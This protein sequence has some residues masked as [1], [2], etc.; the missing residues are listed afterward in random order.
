MTATM[1]ATRRLNKRKFTAFLTVALLGI[2]QVAFIPQAHANALKP[3]P[4]KDAISS[5]PTPACDIN[6][7]RNPLTYFDPKSGAFSIVGGE[8]D[9]DYPFQVG[10]FR[11]K[12]GSAEIDW[13]RQIRADESQ[14]ILTDPSD[15]NFLGVVERL[16][17]GGFG[18]LLRYR[19]TVSGGRQADLEFIYE[20]RENQITILDYQS[21]RFFRTTFRAEEKPSQLFPAAEKENGPSGLNSTLSPQVKFVIS[22]AS[23][24]YL[25]LPKSGGLLTLLHSTSGFDIWMKRLVR[26]PPMGGA[27]L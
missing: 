18:R 2:V 16:P 7:L 4:A 9:F 11:E 25:S 5:Q 15:S 27:L 1:T 19:G 20:D 26:G 21:G 17:E 10:R 3:A 8:G 12:S 24:D 22:R 13:V 23:H 6:R 14:Y